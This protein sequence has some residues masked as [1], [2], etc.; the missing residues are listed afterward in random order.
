MIDSGQILLVVSAISLI[1]ALFLFFV[2]SLMLNYHWRNFGDNRPAVVRAKR[3]YYF[4]SVIL[5]VL[6]F[7]T[8]FFIIFNQNVQI[9]G[10]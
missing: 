4:G 9:I 1:V 7:T 10:G 8:F 2:F 6:I 3:T 5:L